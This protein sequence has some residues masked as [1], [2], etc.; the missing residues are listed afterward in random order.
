MATPHRI[1]IFIVSMYELEFYA[2]G[3]EYFAVFKENYL[4]INDHFLDSGFVGFGIIQIGV[5]PRSYLII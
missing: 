5:T 2:E 4:T 1:A 3:V